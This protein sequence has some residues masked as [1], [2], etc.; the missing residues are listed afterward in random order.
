MTQNEKTKTTTKDIS[1]KDAFRGMIKYQFA[2][3]YSLWR[4][5]NSLAHHLPW[6][7]VLVV[8][9]ASF[10]ISYVNIGQARAERDKYNKENTH[11][12]QELESL[13]NI[14]EIRKEIAK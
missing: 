1:V 8:I 4:T 12:K 3:C 13:Q 10:V 11:L 6:L 5:V 7:I 14:S 9:L 2:F